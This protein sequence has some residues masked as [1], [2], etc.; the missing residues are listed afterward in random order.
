MNVPWTVLILLLGISVVEGYAEDLGNLSANPFAFDSTAN[1]FGPGKSLRAER[2]E[3][4]LQSLRQPLQQPVRDESVR[5]GCA[6]L[7][8]S[9][10]QLS[11]QAQRQSFR[12]RLDQQSI[13]PVRFAVFAGFH[14]QSVR[15]REPIPLRLAE[16]SI[17]QG[18]A[19]RGRPVN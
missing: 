15:R 1:P 6:A 18:M 9:G 5:H 2:R 12:C 3:Q 11:R 7:V 8:R 4:S 13:R 17:W 19:D 16:Q 14:Q 10:R